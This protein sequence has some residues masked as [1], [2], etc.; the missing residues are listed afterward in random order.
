VASEKDRTSSFQVVAESTGGKAF[1]GRNDLDQCFESAVDDSADYYLLGYYLENS[2]EKTPAKGKKPGKDS[3]PNWRKLQVEVAQE[4]INVRARSGF[5]LDSTRPDA[6]A[7]AAD[8]EAQAVAAPMNYTGIQLT[9]RWNGITEGKGG[10]KKAEFQLI[11][12]PSFANIDEADQ[13]R[14]NVDFIAVAKKPTGEVAG[15]ASQRMNVHITQQDLDQFR[16]VGMLYRYLIEVPPGEYT[17]RFVVRDNVSGRI[18]SA[19]APLK[20]D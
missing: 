7:T 1:V 12:P 14:L 19:T 10:K 16:K 9:G 2:G 18:G 20:I 6:V 4:G 8:E 17:V 15:Q 11:L 13:N 3:N 5:F